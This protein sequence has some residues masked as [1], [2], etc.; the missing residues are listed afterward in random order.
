MPPARTGGMRTDSAAIRLANG[1]GRG[2]VM[3]GIT[4]IPGRPMMPS[5]FPPRPLAA[6][7]TFG[8]TMAATL[9][10][11]AANPIHDGVYPLQPEQTVTLAPGTTLTYDSFSD[12]RCP[13]NTQCIWAGRLIFRFIVDGPDGRE[14]FSLG[15]D[16]PVAAP[17]AL[18]GARVSLDV[19]ALPPARAGAGAQA[20]DPMPVTLR[21]SQAGTPASTSTSPPSTP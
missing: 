12:S 9:A 21:I 7:A 4:Q 18:H 6:L 10:G 17:N 2:F 11:C 19:H 3:I 5:R 8:A 16:Q 20:A 15:P 1:A 13:A 14:E